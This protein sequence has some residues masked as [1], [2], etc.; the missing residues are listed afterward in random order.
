MPVPLKNRAEID[1]KTRCVP[2]GGAGR[3]RDNQ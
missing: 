2:R 3:S 1:K